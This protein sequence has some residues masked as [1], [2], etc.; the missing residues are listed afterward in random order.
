M[1]FSRSSFP[2]GFLFGAAT[3]AY[4]IE[5]HAHGGAGPTHWDSFATGPG[6]VVGGQHGAIACDHYRRWEEDLDLMAA[7][8]LDAY[9][10]STSWARVLP[11]GTGAVNVDGLDFYDRLV[12]GLLAR[13]IAPYATLYHWE[14]P[15]ALADRGG[16]RNPD[17]AKW[18][19]DYAQV[20]MARIGDRVAATATINEFW[21]VAWLSHFLGHHAPGLRDLR[22]AARAMHHTLLA[23]GTAVEALRAQGIGNLGLVANLEATFPAADSDRANSAAALHDAL[24][25]QWFLGAVF[26]KEYPQAALAGLER[27]LPA[28]WQNDFATIGAPVDWVGINYYTRQ[29]VTSGESGLFGDIVT[30]PGPLPKTAMGWE[31][32][33]EGLTEFLNRVVRAYTGDTPLF[34]TENGMASAD[35]IGTDGRIDDV[36]RSAFLEAHFEAARKAIDNGV[37]LKGYFVWSLLDNYEWAFGYDK[38]FGMIHVDFETQA[39]TPKQSWHDF[40]AGLKR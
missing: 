39:R 24:F 26:N 13:G 40:T 18:F 28:G 34:I 27:H 10:F 8:G 20:V 7:A 35:V 30:V 31:I 33:P 3:S 11:E 29:F 16:W 2:E 32:Y 12:D 22:A 37:P 1:K 4:Q 25:N 17:I 36:A 38:R 14:L 9:R 21:C 23:H 19:A 15:A 5:G 6:N